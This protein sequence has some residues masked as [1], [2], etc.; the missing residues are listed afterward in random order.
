MREQGRSPDPH[1]FLMHV[2]LVFLR[3]SLVFIYI[4]PECREK[5]IDKFAPELCFVVFSQYVY[6]S[7]K[8]KALD[9]G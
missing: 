8:F 9:K 4:P 1:R 7:M 5:F 2:L 6:L 3:K